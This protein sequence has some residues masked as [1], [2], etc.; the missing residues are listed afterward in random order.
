MSRKPSPFGNMPS[1][2]NSVAG[3][4]FDADPP[5]YQP[6][7]FDTPHPVRMSARHAFGTLGESFESRP[8]AMRALAPYVH[9]THYMDPEL[10][11]TVLLHRGIQ[12]GQF[13]STYELPE[14]FFF[15]GGAEVDKFIREGGWVP[16]GNGAFTMFEDNLPIAQLRISTSP[17][18]NYSFDTKGSLDIVNSVIDLA[19]RQVRKLSD[20]ASTKKSWYSELTDFDPYDRPQFT[21]QEITRE[22]IIHPEYYPFLDGGIEKLMRD[23]V[24][25]D[26]NCM[27][28][29]GEPGGGK[30]SG[31]RGMVEKL[32]LSPIVAMKPA[33]FTHKNFLSTMFS[34]SDGI[35][36]SNVTQQKLKTIFEH[37]EA[38]RPE[39]C[40]SNDRFSAFMK[41]NFGVIPRRERHQEIRIP[42]ILIED[43]DI[44]MARRD[45]GNSLMNQLLNEVDGIGSSQTR[46]VIFTT[47]KTTVEEIDPALIRDG[48]CFGEFHFR[49]LTPSE[50]IAA[51]AAAGLPP[52]EQIPE[53][54]MSLA[55]ALARPKPRYVIGKNGAQFGFN[56]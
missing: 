17:S 49:R 28:W 47:N 33:L 9:G 38:T 45:K 2:G 11:G 19:C 25:G 53:R 52:F 3:A 27:V 4:P 39:S 14:G 42:V 31:F 30:T 46:K 6:P 21:S 12:F 7:R 43:A 40:T 51:R 29:F 10:I 23:F 50:A 18:S 54:E 36:S 32:M 24:N 48:R 22:T 56:K 5:D 1:R 44:L 55:T 26:E 8:E 37:P 20:E 13:D 15:A 41:K 35:S 16:S 34:Q